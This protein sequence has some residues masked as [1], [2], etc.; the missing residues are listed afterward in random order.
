MSDKAVT[1]KE[2]TISEG[3]SKPN[4]KKGF[5]LILIIALALLALI[6]WA[7]IP[8]REFVSD[9]VRLRA[10]MDDKGI[11]GVIMFMG[12]IILQIFS[13]VIPAGPFEIAAGTVFGIGKGILVCVIAMAIASS[14]V[15]FLSRKLGMKFVQLFF[16]KEK[17]ESLSFMHNSSRRNMIV[18]LLYLIPGAP[19]DLLTFVVGMTDMPYG[20]F[21]IAAS[22]CR[23]PSILLTVLSGNALATERPWLFWLLF[24]LVAAAYVIGILAY[25]RYRKKLKAEQHKEEKQ[26]DT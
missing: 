7:I 19:K 10:Y 3:V 26:A 4:R 25:A 11:A 2:E 21:L 12:M 17:I 6:I 15:F 16:T 22:V 1:A 9:P 18:M 23:I 14:L 8:M 20:L 5:L 13:T 24:V